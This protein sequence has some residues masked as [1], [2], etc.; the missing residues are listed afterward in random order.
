MPLFCKSRIDRESL[1]FQDSRGE[2]DSRPPESCTGW[3]AA[4]TG[5]IFLSLVCWV[6]KFELNFSGYIL[7]TLLLAVTFLFYGLIELCRAPWHKQPYPNQN[8]VTL[9][10]DASI[11][12]LGLLGSLA[13]VAFFYW[14]LPE[15]DHPRYRQFFNLTITA[16]PWLL[17]ALIPYFLLIEWR[18]PK[19]DDGFWHAGQAILGHRS[20]VDRQKLMQHGLAVAIKGFFIPVMCVSLLRAIDSAQAITF[21]SDQQ[22]SVKQIVGLVLRYGMVIEMSIAFAGY[23][24]TSRLLDTHIRYADK[25]SASWFFTLMCYVPFSIFFFDQML[26]L[27]LSHRWDDWLN[28]NQIALTI[29][30]GAIVL[31]CILRLWALASFGLRFSNLT[32]RGII[33]NGLYRWTKHPSYIA[34]NAGFFLISV[35]F[36]V[37]PD[38]QTSFK[39]S[40]LLLFVSLVYVARAYYEEKNLSQ[41]PVYRDYALWIERHGVLSWLGHTVPNLSYQFRLKQWLR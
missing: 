20:S 27:Q 5:L 37:G 24:A 1:S 26:S 29:W 8:F 25:N 14:L 10:H 7:A 30:G 9:L 23:L 17:A 13:V 11:K 2:N 38:W 3:L 33:T 19:T 16:L 22:L 36:V 12:Y 15:Y 32:H 41:D 40:L 31:F 18:L 28:G 39:A 21:P 35:P 4:P 6:A 34:K